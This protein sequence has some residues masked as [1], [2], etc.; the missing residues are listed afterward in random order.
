MKCSEEWEYAGYEECGHGSGF[1]VVNSWL[2]YADEDIDDWG[3]L[4]TRL[5]RWVTKQYPRS[6][7]RA[8]TGDAGHL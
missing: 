4:L 1:L 8:L 2:R 7:I 5:L 6:L 3:E